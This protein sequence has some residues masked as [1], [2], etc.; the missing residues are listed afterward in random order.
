MGVENW[1]PIDPMVNAGMPRAYI[2]YLLQHYFLATESETVDQDA[3]SGSEVN[4]A[5]A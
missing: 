5:D 1:Y 2:E 4:Q 3:A